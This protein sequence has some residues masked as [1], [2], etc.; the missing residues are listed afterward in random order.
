MTLRSLMCTPR[1]SPWLSLLKTLSLAATALLIGCAGVSTSTNTV[2]G[3]GGTGGTGGGTSAHTVDLSWDASV[4]ADICCYN[5]YRAVYTN[6]CGSLSK[7]N[8]APVTNTRYT[9]SEVMDGTSYCYATTA[10]NTSNVESH[11]SNIASN[12]Q[13]PTS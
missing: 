12:V 9:D 4:S 2:T 7:I 11:Y 3:T 13:I 8:S 10:I 1:H 6:S 5:V